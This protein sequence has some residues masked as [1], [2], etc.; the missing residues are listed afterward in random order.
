MT[1]S[2]INKII[3][4]MSAKARTDSGRIHVIYRGKDGW[5]IRREGRSRA[6]RIFEARQAAI[7]YAKEI[8]NSGKGSRVVVHKRSGEVAV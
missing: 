7:A 4:G 1:S 2:T 5:A 8:V 6:I 3:K